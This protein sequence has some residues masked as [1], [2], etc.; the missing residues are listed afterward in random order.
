[1]QPTFVPWHRAMKNQ[2]IRKSGEAEETN[3][4]NDEPEMIEKQ[5]PGQAQNRYQQRCM[6]SALDAWDLARLFVQVAVIRGEAKVGQ[7]TEK[8]R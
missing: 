5:A 6:K 7:Q 1:M 8:Q 4:R 3:G 2:F